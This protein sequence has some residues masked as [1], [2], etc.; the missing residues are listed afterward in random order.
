MS[1]CPSGYCVNCNMTSKAAKFIFSN[2][3]TAVMLLPQ[4]NYSDVLLFSRANVLFRNFLL[5]LSKSYGSCDRRAIHL[6]DAWEAQKKKEK[7]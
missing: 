7:E 1:D 3:E 6:E 2:K 5:F 4:N